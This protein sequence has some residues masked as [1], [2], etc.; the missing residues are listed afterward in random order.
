MLPQKLEIGPSRG[1]EVTRSYMARRGT[2]A[3]SVWVKIGPRNPV[4]RLLLA[5]PLIAMMLAILVLIL[6]IL[7]FVLL[8]AALFRA[9]SRPRREGV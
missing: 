2:V 4:L 8:A 7:G 3:R 1:I 9:V 5:P 6:V